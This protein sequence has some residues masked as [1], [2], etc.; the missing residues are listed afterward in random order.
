[1]KGER[2]RRNK[3]KIIKEKKRGI[4][5]IGGRGGGRGRRE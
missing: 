5:R 1:M 3:A 4:K 2:V